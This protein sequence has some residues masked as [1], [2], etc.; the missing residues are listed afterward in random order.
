MP[1]TT[2]MA[3]FRAAL[4]NALVAKQTTGTPTPPLSG[5]QVSYGEPVTS[6]KE[7]VVFG[8]AVEG[9]HEPVA[10]KDGR[11]KRD[12]TY[13]MDV[14]VTVSS[15]AHPIQSEA[16][17]AAILGVV[18]DVLADDPDLSGTPGVL[19]AIP[20]GVEMDTGYSPE[21]TPKTE[22]TLRVEVRARLT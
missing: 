16:R 11:R 22:A 5:V 20:T 17:A 15:K 18:E 4:Y 19:W 9:E 10:L 21:G 12:E 2:T 14:V 8:P 1:T 13:R 7:R 6:Q 3:A